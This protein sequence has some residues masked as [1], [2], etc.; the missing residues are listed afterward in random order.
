MH[1]RMALTASLL[2]ALPL[3]AHPSVSAVIDSG[4][5]VYYSDLEHVWR[6]APDGTKSV[7][8][9]RSGVDLRPLTVRRVADRRLV[10]PSG[11]LWILETTV[12]NEVRVR[13][14]PLGARP[15][16]RR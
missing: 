3:L 5:S 14:V 11:D 9:L 10:E 12:T 4:G 13:R 1:M 7:A 2:L 6:V 8:V 16:P 15:S